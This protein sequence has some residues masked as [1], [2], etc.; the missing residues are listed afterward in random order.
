MR[1]TRTL[2]V[3]WRE[4]ETELRSFSERRASSRPYQGFHG[5][6]GGPVSAPHV[7]FVSD[8]RPVSTRCTDPLVLNQ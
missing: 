5:S 1:E 8:S 7:V 3:M 4:L 2:R 6:H